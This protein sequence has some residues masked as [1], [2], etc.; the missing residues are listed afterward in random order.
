MQS[1]SLEKPC[2]LKGKFTSKSLL[3]LFWV[4]YITLVWVTLFEEISYR[5]INPSLEY[6]RTNWHFFLMEIKTVK[7]IPAVFIDLQN[8]AYIHLLQ[9]VGDSSAGHKH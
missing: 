5:R 9:K 1:L 6:K 3:L 4:F 7:T 8:K 2:W